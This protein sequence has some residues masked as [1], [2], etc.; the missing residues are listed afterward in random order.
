MKELFQFVLDT[1]NSLGPRV[2]SSTKT[3]KTLV[4][5]LPEEIKEIL[6]HRDDLLIKGSMGSTNRSACPWISILNKN[7]TT[8]PQRGLY[9][10][11]LFKCDMSGFYLTLNQGITNFD[12]L[13]N[14]DKYKNA[15]KVSDYFRSE[16]TDTVF[17]KEAISLGAKKGDLGFGYEKTT[18]IQAYYPSRN[19]DDEVLK[20]DLLEMVEIYD[21]IVKHFDSN[22]Y[23]AV[24]QR[25]LAYEVEAIIPAD[26]AVEKIREV[27]DPDNDMPFGFNRTIREVDPFVD[28]DN[29]YTRI[30][31]PKTG[32]ID[33]LKKAIKDG[34]TGLLGERMVIQYEQERLAE[35]GLEEYAEKVRWVSDESDSYGYDIL[36]YNLNPDGSISELYIEVKST[37]SKVDTVFYVSKNEVET[38]KRLA[39]N[40]CVY[41]LYDVNAQQP[42]FYRAYGQI[43]E[44][45]YLD[46]VT[47]MARYKMKRAS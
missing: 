24:I 28:R 21:S 23:D 30:T 40:Y 26:E 47:Y 9:V 22:S 10:V 15:L 43:E 45:F 17:S 25:V 16:I 20:K 1:Y 33:Y 31:V 12:R 32:K 11:F 5:S 19:F 13:Y 46:P 18:I 37:V 39:K 41:R 42:K 38:S 35:M 29:K 8:S 7:V 34:K 6:S 44:N 14:K 36:S 2:D 4:H 27:I 3:H